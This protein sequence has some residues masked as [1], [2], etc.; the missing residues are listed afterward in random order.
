MLQGDNPIPSSI[1]NVGK[2]MRLHSDGYR[3]SPG[4]VHEMIS[5]LDLWFE[6]NTKEICKV[7]SSH[8]R[9]TIMADDV[10]EFFSVVKNGVLE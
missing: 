4:A 9:K 6:L 7:S 2:Q 10:T 3:V 5:R 1:L 8:G